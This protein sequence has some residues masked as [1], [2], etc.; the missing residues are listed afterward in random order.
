MYMN[1]YTHTHT[2]THTY[3][4]QPAATYTQMHSI[5]YLKSETS[6]VFEKPKGRME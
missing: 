5:K 1:V 2:Y 3:L 4:E 6:A